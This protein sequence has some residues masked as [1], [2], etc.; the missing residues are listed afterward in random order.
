MPV[1]RW[2]GNPGK[3]LLFPARVYSPRDSPQ[4][5]GGASVPCRISQSCAGETF[6]YAAR[7]RSQSP[8]TFRVDAP[9]HSTRAMWVTTPRGQN[10]A[11]RAQFCVSALCPLAPTPFDNISRNLVHGFLQ[12]GRCALAW[13]TCHVSDDPEGSKLC[14]Q[15]TI[16]CF[17]LMP[18]SSD[19]LRLNFTKF[20]TLIFMEVQHGL[21]KYVY[22]RGVKK[23]GLVG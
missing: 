6:G 11:R 23:L 1:P 16:L 14:P 13:H 17:S 4:R 12:H 9:W 19:T 20:G 15:G 2:A 18:S 8:Q 3:K 10:C 5:Q 22:V 21:S 7:G